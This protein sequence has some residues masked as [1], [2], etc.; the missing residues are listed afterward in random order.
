MSRWWKAT[1]KNTFYKFQSY[2][3]R[4]KIKNQQN[5]FSPNSIIGTL[6]TKPKCPFYSPFNLHKRNEI[7]I[8]K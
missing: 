3:S 4:Y 1:I 2:I 7:L 8:V 5:I 6:L